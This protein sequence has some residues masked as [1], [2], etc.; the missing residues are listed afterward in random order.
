[1]DFGIAGVVSITVIAYLIGMACKSA[2]FMDDK[3]IPV[4]C[5]LVGCVLG[6]VGMNVMPDFPVHDII[7][8]AAVGIVSG[9]AATGANQIGKQLSKAE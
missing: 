6:I 4:I 1:M 3:W 2:S 8:A 7:S 5:G 9:L